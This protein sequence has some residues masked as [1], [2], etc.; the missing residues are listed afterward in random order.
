MTM[1]GFST[2][3]LERRIAQAQKGDRRKMSGNFYE[4]YRAENLIE[5]GD[6]AEGM[7]LAQ[8]ALSQ[9]RPHF[10]DLLQAHLQALMLKQLDSS[11]TN[12][13]DI[14]EELFAL[15][16]ILLRDRGL[17]MPVGLSIGISSGGDAER[18]QILK[19]A[20]AAGFIQAPRSKSLVNI[21][22]IH[23]TDGTFKASVSAPV[24]AGGSMQLKAQKL[25]DVLNR[26]TDT[27][28]SVEV[29]G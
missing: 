23:E 5:H 27:M 3:A 12:Y 10:D 28:F 21:S 26:L 8:Q 18:Q 19:A 25:S 1:R 6:I 16:R 20:E 9:V 2:A 15:N 11:S 4:A 17:V 24:A 14:A 22:I 13:Q 7:T 29:S